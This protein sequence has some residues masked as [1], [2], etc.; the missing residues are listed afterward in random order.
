MNPIRLHIFPDPE[1]SSAAQQAH[2]VDK[3]RLATV[4][5]IANQA[6]IC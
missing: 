4:A 3:F 5:D 1:L 2:L 6:P